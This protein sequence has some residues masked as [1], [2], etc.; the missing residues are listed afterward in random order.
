MASEL[1]TDT[2]ESVEAIHCCIVEEH[3]DIVPFLHALIRASMLPMSNILL[4]H[5]DAHPDLVPIDPPRFFRDL[6]DTSLFEDAM[7]CDGGIAEFILPLAYNG[8]ISNG[9]SINN[10]EH[11]FTN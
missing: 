5:V 6:S 10:R 2:S 11:T 1:F 4:V 9:K 7:N 3:C 8:H